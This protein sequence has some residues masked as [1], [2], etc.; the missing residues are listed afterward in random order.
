MLAK[1]GMFQLARDIIQSRYDRDLLDQ[2]AT[3]LSKMLKIDKSR[4]K[5]LK[6][7]DGNIAS[8][9]W[10][11]FEKQANTIWPDEMIKDFGKANFPVS[12]FGF[13]NPPVS[14]VKCHNYLKK[15][16]TI[17]DESMSQTLT[18]WRDYINIADQMKMNTKCDQI[19]RPKDLKYSQ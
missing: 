1:L 15:Q 8:L 10:M 7:M 18:T 16:M 3:E 5:R 17:M 12:V 6:E 11:Q 14:F 9:R 4:L 13:L 2:E 19:Q